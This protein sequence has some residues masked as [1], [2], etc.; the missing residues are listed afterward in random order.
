VKPAVAKRAAFRQ[1]AAVLAKTPGPRIEFARRA[2]RCQYTPASSTIRRA[3]Q[4]HADVPGT[5]IA[6]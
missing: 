4:W 2:V 6:V 5:P 1:A 3:G